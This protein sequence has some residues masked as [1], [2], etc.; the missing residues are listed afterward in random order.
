MADLGRFLLKSNH[1]TILTAAYGE[2]LQ[3]LRGALRRSGPTIHRQRFYCRLGELLAS[4]DPARRECIARIPSLDLR[5]LNVI[6]ILP[7]DICRANV[8]QAVGNE[9]TAYDT[10]KAIRVLV[11]RGAS[12]KHLFAAI[13]QVQDQRGLEKVFERFVLGCRAP[14]HPVDPSDYYKPI[15]DGG[16]AVHVARKYR[17]CV[18]TYVL[19]LLDADAGHAFAEASHEGEG[20]IVHLRR[21]DE[22]WRLD[23][24]YGRRN[25]QPSPAAREHITGYLSA[26]GIEVEKPKRTLSDWDAVRRFTEREFMGIPHW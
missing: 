5:K 17:N 8:V 16:Q 23:G 14:K 7:P 21:R 24:L 19:E 20:V 6:S 18:R 4:S 9:D 12:E 22:V 25:K 13:R 10:V 1:A 3:G 15:S 2:R 11:E 26:N